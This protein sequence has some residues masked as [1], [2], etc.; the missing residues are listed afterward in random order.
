MNK[1]KCAV[2]VIG[3]AL[4]FMLALGIAM[5]VLYTVAILLDSIVT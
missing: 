3:E 2:R 1:M 5:A 4:G